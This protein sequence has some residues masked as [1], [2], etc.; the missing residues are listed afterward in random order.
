MADGNPSVDRYL[1]DK[2][3]DH[4]DHA[5]G[6]PVEPLAPTHRNYFAATVGSAEALA[7]DA[8]P[9]WEPC[10]ASG[11][12]GFWR[13]SD[14]GRRTLAA[15]LKAIGDPHRPYAVTYEGTTVVVAAKSASAAKYS[16]FLRVSD[17]FQ[18]LTFRK[19]VGRARSVLAARCKVYG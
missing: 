6:R 16:L 3:M 4:I 18:E 7:F 14:E 11:D 13:V 17:S 12:M 5:L 1:K 10:G 19:F 9:N 8:S 2:A 15:H